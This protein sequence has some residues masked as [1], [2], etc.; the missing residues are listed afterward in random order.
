MLLR[1]L[2][3]TIFII[4]KFNFVILDSKIKMNP[5]NK[6]A[7]INSNP[8]TI[9]THILWDTCDSKTWQ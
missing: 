6:Q 8:C 9:T 1:I 5:L 4:V 3:I 7:L 2:L